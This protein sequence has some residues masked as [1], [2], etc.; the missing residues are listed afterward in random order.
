MKK[1]LTNDLKAM[2]KHVE[3]AADLLKSI[4]NTHRLM[5]LCCLA[6]KELSVSELN[7]YVSLSQSALS[8]HLAYLR[9]VNL[10]KTRRESQTIYY[11]LTGDEAIKIIQVLKSIYCP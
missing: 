6:G 5:I 9:E 7:A 1:A 10:V 4:A 3:K 8:Q 11:Q 2:T